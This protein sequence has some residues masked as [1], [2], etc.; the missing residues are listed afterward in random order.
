MTNI[1][2]LIDQFNKRLELTLEPEKQRWRELAESRR[3]IEHLG[4][5]MRTFI[6]DQA[7]WTSVH[8]HCSQ[9]GQAALAEIRIRSKTLIGKILTETGVLHQCELE[10]EHKQ[11]ELRQNAA[12]VVY[13]ALEGYHAYKPPEVAAAI[14][15]GVRRVDLFAPPMT[16]IDFHNPGLGSP[17]PPSGLTHIND[18]LADPN[19]EDAA[20]VVRPHPLVRPDLVKDP[21]NSIPISNM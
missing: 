9:A 5:M 19:T 12:V 8:V 17:I 4:D 6:D 13:R 7:M 1:R 2:P 11:D 14:Q 21:T 10:C 3:R 15:P 18:G 20:G 16:R